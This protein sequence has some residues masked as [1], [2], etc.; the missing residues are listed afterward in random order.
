MKEPPKVIFLDAVGTLF[1]IRGS[2]GEVY[3]AIAQQFGVNVNAAAL[4]QAFLQSFQA[5]GAPAFADSDPAELQAKE[6]TWW[7]GVATQTFKQTGVFHQFSDFGEFFAHLYAYF[8]TAA[9]WVIYPDV[10][11]AL[12]RWRQRG[13]ELGIISNFDSRLYQVLQALELADFFATV[14]ISTEVGFA[15]PDPHIFA[16]ALQKHHCP[17]TSAWHIGDSFGEDYQAAQAVGM[18]GI[19][20]RR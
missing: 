17:A 2:V 6:F 19:W 10:Q 18:R 1:G 11:S 3:G 16:I 8:A 15:K 20:L 12:T 9:P 5:A 13:I 4:N 7:L 14:T